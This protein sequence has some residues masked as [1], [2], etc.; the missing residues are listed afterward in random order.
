MNWAGSCWGDLGQRERKE[1]GRRRLVGWVGKRNEEEV[2][3]F[4]FHKHHLNKFFFEFKQNLNLGVT[5]GLLFHVVCTG[6]LN[7]M[8]CLS[9]WRN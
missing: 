6:K 2:L 3:L 8:K 5:D 1:G 9:F 7:L 4:F